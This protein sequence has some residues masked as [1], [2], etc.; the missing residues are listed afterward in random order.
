MP[1]DAWQLL[2]FCVAL[3]LYLFWSARTEM[4]TKM[5]K[6]PGGDRQNE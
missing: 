5:R 4:G 3:G 1:R 2:L 6:K